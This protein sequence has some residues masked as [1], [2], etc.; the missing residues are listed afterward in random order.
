MTP[1]RIAAVILAAGSSSRMGFPKQLLPYKSRPLLLHMIE[2]AVAST[3]RPVAVVVG[4][5]ADLLRPHLLNLP[6]QLIENPAWHT[7]LGSSITASILALQSASPAIDAALFLLG[8]QPL[9]SPD[10]L[11]QMVDAYVARPTIVACSYAQTFGP[12]VLFD[13]QYFPDLLN[14]PPS[15]GAKPF[16]QKHQPH[17]TFIPFPQGQT[18]IDTPDDYARL[19]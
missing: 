13:R 5:H 3:C 2:I 18:D 19:Q 8:D 14:L 4:C 15:Q 6:V 1:R 12:P 16:I 7:G 10:L 9:I 17:T 11:N